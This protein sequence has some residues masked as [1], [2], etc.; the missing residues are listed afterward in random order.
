[1]INNVPKYFYTK[2]IKELKRVVVTGLGILY[3]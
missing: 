1:M 3:K 2:R